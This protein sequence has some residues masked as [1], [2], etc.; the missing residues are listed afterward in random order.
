MAVTSL[1]CLTRGQS[2]RGRFP[3]KQWEVGLVAWRR[4]TGCR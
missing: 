3:M 1:A 2:R 4:A